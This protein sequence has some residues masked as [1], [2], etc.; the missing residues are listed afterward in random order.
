MFLNGRVQAELLAGEGLSPDFGQQ[1]ESLWAP[2]GE[3]IIAEQGRRAGTLVVG[4]CGPQGSG[5]STGARVLAT[6][7]GEAGLRTAALS[8]DDLYLSRADRQQLA[9]ATGSPLFRT[10]G[11]PGTHD[12]ALGC[13]VLDALARP[14]LVRLPRFD[15]AT[16]NP[17]DPAAWPEVEGPVDV[18]LF[19]GWC[20]GATPQPEADLATPINAM[21]RVE[22]KQAHWRRYANNCLAGSYRGLFERIDLLIQLR[23]PAFE[24]V[25][26]WRLEQE[27]KLRARAGGGMTD[28]EIARFIQ[29]YE[30]L[31][32]WIDVEMPSRADVVVQLDENRRPVQIAEAEG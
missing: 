5:K 28:T 32:R 30:R 9:G 12:V 4:L 18:V 23:A 17:V 10:R 22:D 3:R 2:L 15:K 20:V 31:T 14:G 24:T 11:P 7:L 13:E 26:G 16:D 25:H 21:E 8:L 6:G 1:I 19:E 27:H 29:H